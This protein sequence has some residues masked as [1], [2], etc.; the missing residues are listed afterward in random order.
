MSW[1]SVGLHAA[2]VQGTQQVLEV[3]DPAVYSLTS[4]LTGLLDVGDVLIQVTGDFRSRHFAVF[5]NH[6]S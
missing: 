6:V 5:T 1:S 2:G 4:E 3:S